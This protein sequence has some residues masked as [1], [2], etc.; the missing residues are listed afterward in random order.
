MNPLEQ[1][2]DIHLSPE[3]SNWP[4]AYGWWLLTL[5]SILIIVA[6]I[7]WQFKRYQTRGV[8]RQALRELS[9]IN[10][11]TP[12]WP[13]QLNSLLKR[14]SL[15]YF[16]NSQIA[17]L[18]NQSWSQFLAEQLPLNKRASFL[19]HFQLLQSSL[20]QKSPSTLPDFQLTTKSIQQ[21][22][23]CSLPPSKKQLEKIGGKNV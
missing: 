7:T 14:V 23:K 21:W 8:K 11:N 22:L 2:K 20:Y 16:P 4:P 10:S 17:N 18:Y 12:E 3:I 19:Q 1:L 6:I 9:Q 13:L 5:V 15:N